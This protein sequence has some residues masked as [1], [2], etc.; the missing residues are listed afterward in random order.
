[1][2][3]YFLLRGT[4]KGVISNVNAEESK[5][6]KAVPWFHERKDHTR[7]TDHERVLRPCSYRAVLD[8]MPSERE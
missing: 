4:R 3:K 5:T 2:V 8:Q 7:N 6:E 1:M